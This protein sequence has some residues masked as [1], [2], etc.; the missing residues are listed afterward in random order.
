M[1]SRNER[2]LGAIDRLER[3]LNNLSVGSSDHPELRDYRR[4]ELAK[5][6]VRIEEIERKIAKDRRGDTHTGKSATV[7]KSKRRG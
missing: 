4:L 5:V 6:R 7:F 3:E 2:R 1:Q